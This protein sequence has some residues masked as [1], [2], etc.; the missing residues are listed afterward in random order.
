MQVPD[1][2]QGVLLS[3]VDRLSEELKQL[4][5]KAAVIGRVFLYRIL[6]RMSSTNPSLKEQLAN[7]ETL[8]LVHERCQLPEIEF[9]FKHA[10]T[11]EVAYQTLLAPARKALHQKVGDALESLFRDRLE[12]FAGTLAYHFFSAESWPKALEY[13]IRS[14]DA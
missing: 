1:T 8:D 4:T 12:E 10:L 9:I 14:G 13:S 7:L 2:M 11:Q 3:R 5:Q 6:E